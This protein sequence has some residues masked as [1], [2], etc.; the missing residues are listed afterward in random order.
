MA[1]GSVL[2][3]SD[4]VRRASVNIPEEDFFG[5]ITDLFARISLDQSNGGGSIG[6][7]EEAFVAAAERLLANAGAGF[8]KVGQR[9]AGLAAS[10]ESAVPGF[11][12]GFDSSDPGKIASS[13]EQMLLKFAQVIDGFTPDHLRK[14]LTNSFD[15]LRTDLGL[16]EDFVTAQ[17]KALFRDVI[18]RLALAPALPSAELR[19]NRLEIIALLRRIMRKLLDEFAL[20]EINTA[21]LADELT[22][23]MRLAGIDRMA[24]ELKA[25]ADGL[26][27][28]VT[29]GMTVQDAVSLRLKVRLEAHTDGPSPGGGNGK[30]DPPTPA[31]AAATQR[32]QYAWYATWLLEHRKQFLATRWWPGD[33]VL[34]SGDKTQIT[35]GSETLGTGTDLDWSKALIFQPNVSPDFTFRSLPPGFL[36]GWTKYSSLFSDAMEIFFNWF[37]YRRCHPWATIANTTLIVGD[38]VTNVALNAPI[39]GTNVVLKSWN[40]FTLRA[41]TNF[42]FSFE[43]IGD[44]ADQGFVFWILFLFSANNLKT[45]FFW[46]WPKLLHDAVLSAFTLINHDPPTGPGAD[47]ASR[48]LNR[49]CMDYICRFFNEIVTMIFVNFPSRKEYITPERN[50]TLFGWWLGLGAVAS[51]FGV[52]IGWAAGHAFLRFQDKMSAETLGRTMLN[53]L[54]QSWATFWPYYYIFQEGSTKDGTYNAGRPD[55]PG[56]PDKSTSPYRLPY[57]SGQCRQCVQGNQGMFSHNEQNPASQIYAVDFAMSAEEILAARGGTVVD[58]FDWVPDGTRN[59]VNIPVTAAPNQSTQQSWNFVAIRHDANVAG[60]DRDETTTTPLTTFAVYGHGRTGSVRQIFATRLGLTLAAIT[61]ANIIGQVVQQGQPIMLAGHTGISAFN[62]LH[63]HV[64]PDWTLPAGSAQ[65]SGRETIPFVFSD[66]SGNGVCRSGRYFES[67]NTRIP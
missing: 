17:V 20:P 34:V 6:I 9:F 57:A 43:G 52:S 35:L 50:P 7:I 53:S 25:F 32:A 42:A 21:H 23:W 47:D 58:F 49:D 62:H 33:K 18:A 48:P 4:R 63:M 8:D 31:P 3:Q 11:A 51:F 61:P 27:D 55:F 59:T 45:Y 38:G 1:I 36:E 14:A 37:F 66:V 44:A 41:A 39:S 29:A 10:L 60:H 67:T 12:A 2:L 26:T 13:L 5:D 22:V 64:V 15:V 16:S 19:D 56:Y 46:R 54:L 65:F 28:L 24:E 30:D 40:D